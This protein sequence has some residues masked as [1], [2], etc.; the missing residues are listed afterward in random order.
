MKIRA[1]IEEWFNLGGTFKLDDDQPAAN[2]LKDLKQIQGL[3]EKL[4]PLEVKAPDPAP[5]VVAAAEFLLEGM[6]AHRKLSRSLEHGFAA[7]ERQRRR[8]RDEF[9]PQ[10]EEVEIDYEEWQRSRKSRRGGLN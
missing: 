4:K 8:E 10:R 5:R 9:T 7:Q 3:I 2:A 1:Q 6:A